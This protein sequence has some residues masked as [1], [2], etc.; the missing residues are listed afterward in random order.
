MEYAQIEQKIQKVVDQI[1]KEFQPEKIILFGSW[2]WGTPGANS[3]VDLFVVKDTKNTRMLAREIDGRI[4]PRPFPL[5]LI[6]YRPEQ[7]QKNQLQ[8]DFFI[9]AILDKG[10]VLYAQ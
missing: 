2:A 6:V 4:F 9:T 1:V 10:K 7:I 3:D 8:G 5:D